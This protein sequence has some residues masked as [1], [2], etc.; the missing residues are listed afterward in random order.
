MYSEGNGVPQDYVDAYKWFSL[1]VGK[2]VLMAKQFLKDITPQKT[3]ALIAETQRLAQEWKPSQ[4]ELIRAPGGHTY[5]PQLMWPAIDR[6][7]TD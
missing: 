2:G 7:V 1:V 5:Y 6:I 4:V 3:S